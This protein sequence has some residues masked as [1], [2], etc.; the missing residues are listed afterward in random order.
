MT[1]RSI[2]E[3]ANK[4]KTYPVEVLRPAE[5][6]AL[7]RACSNRA[8]T[9]I[10]NRA[11]ITIMWRGMLRI[12]E[13][14]S[15]QPKDLDPDTGTVRILRGKGNKARTIAL[16]P[17]AF[18]VIQRWLDRRRAMG[19]HGSA[20]VFCTLDGK[21]MA[22]SYARALF[23]RLGRKAGVAKRVHPHCLRHTGAFE[24]HMEG[25]P[26][27]AIQVQLGHSNL[28]TT[29]R[30]LQHIAPADVA[31]IMRERRWSAA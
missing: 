30:Y 28:A 26:L 1:T 22:S 31:R 13:A 29:S 3:P 15:I 23:A 27:N 7:I 11:L 2:R 17:Q 21:P 20:P 12:S 9:G 10:R 8:P 5:V 24:L 16:D 6:V 4:G 14:L 18:A 25:V 19:I